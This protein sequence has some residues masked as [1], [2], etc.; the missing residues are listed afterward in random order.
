MLKLYGKKE[1][2]NVIDKKIN[3]LSCTVN[4]S[5]SFNK[6]NYVEKRDP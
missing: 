3:M 4:G 5:V 2:K 6:R 1:I